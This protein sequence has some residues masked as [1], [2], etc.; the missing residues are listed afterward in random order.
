MLAKY[1]LKNAR[2]RQLGHFAIDALRMYVCSIYLYVQI[3]LVVIELKFV[4][5]N[6]WPI[7]IMIWLCDNQLA[8]PL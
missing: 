2:A 6:K 3:V 8:R 1:T 4:I 7:H 5:N